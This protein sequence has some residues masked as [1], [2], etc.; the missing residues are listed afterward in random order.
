MPVILKIHAGMG[1]SGPTYRWMHLALLAG[2]VTLLGVVIALAPDREVTAA[3]AQSSPPEQR[4]ELV[5]EPASGPAPGF[6]LADR[7]GHR[8]ALSDLEG[9]YV[10]VNFWATWCVPCREELP[11][12]AVLARRL[13]GRPLTLV[14]VSVDDGWPDIDRLA[15]DLA[16][17]HR[18]A[19]GNRVLTDTL[20]MLRGELDNVVVLLDAKA[21]AA[22]RYG[23]SKYPETYLVGPEGRLRAKFTGPRPWG[24]EGAVRRLAAMLEE[25][26]SG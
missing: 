1:A 10:L 2:G 17:A 9:R 20:A 13:H 16:G 8:V 4:A 11:H 26:S 22:A 25:P 14:L 12:L 7:A 19:A 3:A 5:A 21:E 23:T 18:A 6:S 24:L 15:A